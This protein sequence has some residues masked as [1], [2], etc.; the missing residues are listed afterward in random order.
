[1][2]DTLETNVGIDPFQ[3]LYVIRT[4]EG[5]F[6]TWGWDV[7]DD[8]IDRMALNLGMTEFKAP[9][10]GTREHYDT[11]MTLSEGLRRHWIATH[12]R[13]V[14]DLSP[15]LIGLEGHRVEVCDD[16]GDTPRR[17]IVGKSTGWAPIHLEIKT[18]RS[19]GGE[20][21]RREYHSVRDLG[22][23]NR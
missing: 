19:M 1:M 14:F 21:A 8:R 2:N 5:T 16:E 23:S 9:A 6:S 7:V 13:A 12:E 4:P 18:T 3:R 10:K 11:M 22:P 17:F 20:G 15:Q